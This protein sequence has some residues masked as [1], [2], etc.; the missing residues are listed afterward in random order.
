MSHKF[1]KT[2]GMFFLAALV[3]LPSEAASPEVRRLNNGFKVVYDRME[4]T[5]VVS[6]GIWVK[7]GSI[8]ENPGQEGIAH[9]LEHMLFKGSAHY[10]PGAAERKIESLGGRMNGATS[11]EY[12][13]YYMSIPAVNFKEAFEVLSDMIKNPLFSPEEF[14]SEKLVVLR[15]VDQREDS[16]LQRSARLFYQ[17]AYKERLY[18]RPI[19]GFKDTINSF[20]IEDLVEF[21]ETHYSPDNMVLVVAGDAAR[22][23]VF[24][25]AAKHFGHLE[26]GGAPEIHPDSELQDRVYQSLERADIRSV[27]M[28]KGY[29]G[30]GI[31]EAP[32]ADLAALSVAMNILGRGRSSRLYQSLREEKS[33]VSSISAGFSFLPH[34]G[35]VYIRAEF[36]P[37]MDD[38]VTE[39]IMEEISVFIHEGPDPEEFQWARILA[40]TDMIFGYEGSSGRMRLYGNYAASDN[41][42]FISEYARA[43]ETLSLEQVL[44]AIDE[45]LLPEKFS[46]VKLAPINSGDETP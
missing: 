14:S 17:T 20:S 22:R 23:D 1:F 34:G 9:M 2:L 6:F 7:T 30:P 35:P 16:P 32:A 3:H 42:D 36:E 41:I 28:W 11:F 33:I 25:L 45:Y 27:Y 21:H 5:G 29:P 44:R 31:G 46:T 8:H 39:A 38:S 12:T 43:L 15:E 13:C 24:K 10:P 19:I 26:P 37:G 4:G 18:G 40:V